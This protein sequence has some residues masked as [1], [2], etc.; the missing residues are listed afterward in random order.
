MSKDEANASPPSA[1]AATPPD[2]F[3]SLGLDP[4]LVATLTELGYEEPTP[5]QREAIPPMLTGR[6]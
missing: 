4:K 2:G 5:I 1:A 6:A 3:G